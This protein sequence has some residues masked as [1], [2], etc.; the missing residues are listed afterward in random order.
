VLFKRLQRDGW[1][2]S[3]ESWGEERELTSLSHKF[4]VANVG[5]EGWSW[6]PTRRH[7]TLRTW[8]RGYFERGYTFEF[9]IDEFPGLLDAM[10]EWATWSSTGDLLTARDGVIHRFPLESLEK[11]T[12]T[13][14][15]D[16]NDY[17]PPNEG[18]NESSAF[19]D[20]V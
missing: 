8:Y 1:K 3:G 12:P 20:R 16:C 18:Q 9:E 5:D 14:S 11:R 10:V 19:E 4:C 17:L 13:F 15:F 2:R 6:R 7:P